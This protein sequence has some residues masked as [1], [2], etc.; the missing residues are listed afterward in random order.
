VGG[1]FYARSIQVSNITVKVILGG[2]RNITG[3]FERRSA[4]EEW[5][6][7]VVRAVGSAGILPAILRTVSSANSNRDFVQK[8]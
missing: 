8:N 1:A 3:A 4:H 6:V 5:M 2:D 7:G